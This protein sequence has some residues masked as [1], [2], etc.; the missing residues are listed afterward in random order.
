MALIVILGIVNL[1]H[2]DVIN[3]G[4]ETGDL[5]GWNAIGTVTVS[6]TSFGSGPTQGSYEALITNNGPSSDLVPFIGIPWGMC[7]GGNWCI[8]SAIRQ[9]F[10]A[11]K[12]GTLSFDFNLLTNESNYIDQWG[13]VDWQYPDYAFFRLYSQSDEYKWVKLAEVPLPIFPESPSS[14]NTN[15]IYF[16]ELGFQT[17]SYNFTEYDLYT[18]V[19]GVVNV[20]D[21][22]VESALLIDNIKI[23][24]PE[25][26]TMLLLGLG[27][28]GLAVIRKRIRN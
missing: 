22:A 17:F 21:A 5:Q 18:L 14:H 27:L 1:T 7:A 20:G 3:G 11:T 2:A 24:V 25:P 6:T 16:Q 9:S 28:V 26:A 23:T 4:F 10:Y 19:I 12:G 13:G 15:T 8:G